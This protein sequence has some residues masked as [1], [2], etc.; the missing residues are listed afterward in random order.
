MDWLL[1][2]NASLDLH[3]SLLFLNSDG[4]QFSIPFHVDAVVCDSEPSVNVTCSALS[5]R[6][7]SAQLSQ[8]VTSL[9]V[10]K[11]KVESISS[12]TDSQRQDLFR[13]LSTHQVVFNEF[14]SRTDKY[15]HVIKMH[16]ITPFLTKG[17]PIA[18][19]LRLEVEAVI[20]QMLALGVIKREASPF[21]SPLTVVRKKDGSVRIW[22]DARWVNQ[23]MVADCETPRPPEDLLQSFQS[24]RFMSTI[25]LRSSYWQIPLSPESTQYTAFLFN[26]QSYTY[27]VLSFGLKTAVGSFSRAMNVILG[28]GAGIHR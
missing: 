24:I 12:L 19:S 16:D 2:V 27:Q 8:S 7:L 15:V 10:L 21:A 1:S 11:D 9:C 13:V 26:G 5:V 23:R 6:G 3:Q 14:P 17:Y 4:S 25:D 28:A 20:E 18:F 22:L